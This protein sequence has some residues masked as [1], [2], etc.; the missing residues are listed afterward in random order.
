MK[1]NR[2]FLSNKVLGPK[3][4]DRSWWYYEDPEGIYVVAYHGNPR[5][6]NDIRIS[7]GFAQFV[8]PWKML[9]ETVKRAKKGGYLP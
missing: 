1:K 7:V 4:K 6:G 3:S 2:K 9:A 8:V 5:R